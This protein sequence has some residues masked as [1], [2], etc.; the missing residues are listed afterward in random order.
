ME[1]FNCSG[2]MITNDA[3]CTREIEARIPM[4]KAAFNR[5]KTLFT[6]KLD[7]ELRKKL[8]KCYIWSIAFY[9]TEIRSKVPGK[10]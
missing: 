8:V 7:L 4:A 10:F 5:K 6:R 9:G 1:E 2:N 3:R